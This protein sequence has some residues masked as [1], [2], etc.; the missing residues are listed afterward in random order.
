LSQKASRE[1]AADLAIQS[2]QLLNGCH[3]RLEE[4]KSLYARL[5]LMESKPYWLDHLMKAFDEKINDYDEAEKLLE[6]TIDQLRAGEF[7]APPEEIR[8]NIEEQ[9]GQYFQYWL[10]C[11]PFPNEAGRG[12]ETDFLESM[13]GEAEASPTP[14][15]S[16]N[17]GIFGDIYW[18]KYASPLFSQV[19]LSAVFEKNER[20]V[21]YAF[22][23]I[24]SPRRGEV[25]ATIGSNDGIQ[26]FL[27]GR[28]IYKKY[29]K[30]SLIPDEDSVML[31]LKEGRNDLLLKIDQNKGGWGFSFRLPAETVRNHKYKYYILE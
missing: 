30:R 26:V 23:R 24:Y 2:G 1:Q 17:A 18:Q 5:W 28:R 19:D 14:G 13:G 3:I 9:K 22:C 11:G 12:R 25:E 31:P 29:I 27:N 20:T 15:Y 4:L 21:A 6:K 8:L 10:L 16:F 7:L